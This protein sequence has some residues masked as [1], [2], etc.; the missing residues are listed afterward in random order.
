MIE[1]DENMACRINHEWCSSLTMAKDKVLREAIRLAGG[2]RA[3]ARE[4]GIDHAA[5]I[6]WNRAPPLRVLEIE[7]LTGISRHRLR[8]DVYGPEPR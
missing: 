7:R 2:V 6:R 5:I 4:L 1:A 8:P 3:L